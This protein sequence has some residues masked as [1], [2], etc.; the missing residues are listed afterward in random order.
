MYEV[1]QI[2]TEIQRNAA[3]FLLMETEDP[4]EILKSEHNEALE[5]LALLENAVLSISTSGFSAEAF[6]NIALA[7]RF[8]D[9]EFRNHDRKEEEFLFPLVEK[10]VSGPPAVMRSEHR[11]LWNAFGQLCQIVRD[12]EEGKLHGKVIAELIQT[13][14]TVITLLRHHIEKENTVFFPLTKRLLTATEYKHLQQQ[15]QSAH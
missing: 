4:I 5:K 9:S 15:F 14:R 7:I 10:H 2:Q 3:H 8:L 1:R 6:Q 12:V 11:S 13:S